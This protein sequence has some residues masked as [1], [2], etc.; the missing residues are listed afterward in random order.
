MQTVSWGTI[1]G[2][3]VFTPACLFSEVGEAEQYGVHGVSQKEVDESNQLFS[4][5]VAKA[6]HLPAAE[7]CR[8]VKERY[9]QLATAG[10]PIAAYN[11]ERLYFN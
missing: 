9:G 11:C 1:L 6:I 3:L 10:N 5:E 2:Y 4:R 7:L 8:Q